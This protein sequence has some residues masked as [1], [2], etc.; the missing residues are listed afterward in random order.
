MSC[1][2]FAAVV[3]AVAQITAPTRNYNV[4][5]PVSNGPYVIGQIL[6]CTYRLFSDVDSSGIIN[7]L[8]KKKKKRCLN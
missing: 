5:S 3:S 2:V 7:I 6:P 8:Q 4:T 1:L